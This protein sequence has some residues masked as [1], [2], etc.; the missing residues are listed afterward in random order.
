MQAQDECWE[1]G[2]ACAPSHVHLESLKAGG[3]LRW[4]QARLSWQCTGLSLSSGDLPSALGAALLPA[5]SISCTDT[6]ACVMHDPA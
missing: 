2:E 6:L 1:V 4:R 3:G 5:G